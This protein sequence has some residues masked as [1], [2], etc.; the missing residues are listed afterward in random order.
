MYAGVSFSIPVE[1]EFTYRI[2]EKYLPYAKPGARVL[3]QFG[4]S[5]KRGYI[6]SLSG[7]SGAEEIIRREIKEIKKIID[8]APALTTELLR[9]AKWMSDN[10][11]CS[12]GEA[13]DCI[14]PLTAAPVNAGD[15]GSDW[16]LSAPLL[17]VSGAPFDV[18]VILGAAR[19]GVPRVFSVS[20]LDVRK[21]EDTYFYL[22][23]KTAAEIN[24]GCILVMPDYASAGA[25]ARRLNNAVGGATALFHTGLGA[26]SKADV[27]SRCL[28]GKVRVLVGARA[29]VFAPVKDLRM[30]IVENDGSGLHKNPQKPFYD[31]VT[32]AEERAR[33]AGCSAVLGSFIPS[34]ETYYRIKKR[35]YT[36][37][38]SVHS[39]PQVLLARL[40][41]PGRSI[42]PLLSVEI[43]KRL[44]K[45]ELSIIFVNRRGFSGAVACPNCGESPRCPNCGINLV[46]HE[47]GKKLKC[48]YCGYS[49]DFTGKC[50]K[51]SANYY[52]VGAGTER[53]AQDVAQMFPAASIER[54][55]SDSVS[56]ESARRDVV[57][58]IAAG[59]IDILTVTQA[60][61]GFFRDFLSPGARK[62]T[63][64]AVHRAESLL[65]LPDFRAFERALLAIAEL[66]QILDERGEL[67][68]QAL[69]PSGEFFRFIGKFDWMGY[70][71]SEIA[72]RE[73]LGYPPA[74]RL[75]NFVMR[76]KSEK[77]LEKYS[78]AA[79]DALAGMLSPSTATLL[80]PDE[81]PK[82]KIR[83]ALRRHILIKTTPVNLKDVSAAIKSL[84]PPRGVKTAADV[85]PYEII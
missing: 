60:I 73:E 21:R 51:C 35:E 65:Y 19:A 10:L 71:D 16:I 12:Y 31:V 4:R 47:A 57:A 84:K 45:N 36:A 29:A 24:G 46:Y 50:R 20:G 41:R 39:A 27:W 59:R 6:T 48:H 37:V 44:L 14:F 63:L 2:P 66:A 34:L 85:N 52:F 56:S 54:I 15:G 72:Y 5:S 13:L 83:G 3:V 53:V 69:N 64:I 67:L 62:P 74:A 43:E 42:S 32:I 9:V 81:P 33:I 78:R 26:R 76:S 7:G 55:D 25:L 49:E 23:L 11:A 40:D 28:S 75:V 58:R 77:I 22:A 61:T 8:A 1:K 38:P 79:Y 17:E 70:Y 82:E 18:S 30:I 80:G 68:V